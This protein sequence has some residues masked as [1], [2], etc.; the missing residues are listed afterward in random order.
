MGSKK[1]SQFCKKKKNNT[2]FI[3]T[4]FREY[5]SEILVLPLLVPANLKLRL[6]EKRK[7]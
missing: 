3:P 5:V 4:I 1:K 6:L 7:I 2:I